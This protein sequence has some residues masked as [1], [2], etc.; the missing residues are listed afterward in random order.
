MTNPVLGCIMI[1]PY[2]CNDFVWQG[3]D[4]AALVEGSAGPASSVKGF[5]WKL[6]LECSGFRGE[7]WS[8]RLLGLSHNGDIWCLRSLC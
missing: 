3:Q 5:A 1:Q 4:L 6:D 8:L 7:H 2:A